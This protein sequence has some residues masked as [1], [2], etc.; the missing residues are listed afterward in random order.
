[1]PSE[2]DLLGAIETHGVEELHSLLRSGA[3]AVDTINGFTPVEYLTSG[4]LRSS[5]FVA[6][7]GVLLDAGGVQHDAEVR[8]VLLDD[9]TTLEGL[10]RDNKNEVLEKR[11]SMRAAF[12]QCHEV[13]LLH[14]CA[15]FN[16][17]RCARVLLEAGAD[18]N[19]AAGID[20]HGF[21]GQT[22]LFHAVNSN[23]NY[24][25]PAMELLV[26]HGASL[27]VTIAGLVWGQEMDWETVIL[28]VNPLSYAQCGLYRQFHRRESDVYSN[29]AFLYEHRYRKALHVR[30][31]PNKYLA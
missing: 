19:A 17:M 9:S 20:E 21:G 1:M 13:S 11:V 24:C 27:D 23:H 14:L 8:A 28:A 18:V 15:E 2:S 4:Y 22:P 30:N 25:R 5:R 26:E 6:C 16:S 7:L 12:T 3:S 31:V 29:L 10:L